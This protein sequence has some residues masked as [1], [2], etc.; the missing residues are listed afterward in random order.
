MNIHRKLQKINR[1]LQEVAR[2]IEIAKPS[3][4]QR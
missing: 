4:A 1:N 2:E 3:E